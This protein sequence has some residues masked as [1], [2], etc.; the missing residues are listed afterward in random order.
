MYIRV[1]FQMLSHIM[2]SQGHHVKEIQ[3]DPER[4]PA[5]VM[6]EIAFIV[7]LTSSNSGISQMAAK[8]LRTIA[9]LQRQPDAP[10]IDFIQPE[11]YAKRARVY[12]QL[13]DPK[14]TVVGMYLLYRY[15]H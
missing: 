9:T 15:H 13:G 11:D 6:A 10:Q 4:V 3:V 8:G 2:F 7:T 5:F 1:F 14:V 12:E